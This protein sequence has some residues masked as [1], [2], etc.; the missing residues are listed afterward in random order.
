MFLLHAR[1]QTKWLVRSNLNPGA[2]IIEAG[3]AS[4]LTEFLP[5]F[6]IIRMMVK[7][8]EEFMKI[9]QRKALIQPIGFVYLMYCFP[10]HAENIVHY[11]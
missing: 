6:V 8:T 10:N 2:Q 7:M 9:Q 1:E 3:F 11:S 4:K 5:N